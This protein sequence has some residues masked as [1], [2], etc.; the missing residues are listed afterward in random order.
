MSNLDKLIILTCPFYFW[1]NDNID[2][3]EKIT[4]D[5]LSGLRLQEVAVSRLAYKILQIT[6]L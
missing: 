3:T 6:I 4:I 1:I 5:L 2:T